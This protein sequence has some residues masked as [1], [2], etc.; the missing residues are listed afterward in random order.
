MKK[1]FGLKHLILLTV[2]VIAFELVDLA[3]ERSTGVHWFS[4]RDFKELLGLIAVA[5]LWIWYF[6][7]KFRRK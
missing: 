2:A 7:D 4:P 6:A 5:L 1:T 3:F